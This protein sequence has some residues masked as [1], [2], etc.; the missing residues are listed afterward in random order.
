M[1]SARHWWQWVI[2]G[3]GERLGVRL[4]LAVEAKH[5]AVL[6]PGDQRHNIMDKRAA[7]P[8]RAAHVGHAAIVDTGDQ[9]RIYFHQHAFGGQPAY[10]LKLTGNQDLSRFAP[11][12]AFA[13]QP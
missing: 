2:C 4:R 1:A 7:G 3:I 13:V 10:A 9:H 12:V 5:R 11:A 6:R 8:Q